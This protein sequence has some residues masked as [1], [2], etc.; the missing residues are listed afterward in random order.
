MEYSE[1]AVRFN[2]LKKL[3]K[4]AEYDYRLE[5]FTLLKYRGREKNVTLPNCFESIAE[6]AFINN[7]G[8]RK[9]VIP[10]SYTMIGDS[11]FRG[12]S[13][14]NSVDLGNI[15]I[16]G[17]SVFS[18]CGIWELRLPSSV[19][20]VGKLAFDDNKPLWFIEIQGKETWFEKDSFRACK[21]VS[22]LCI[23]KELMIGDI[24]LDMNDI[25]INYK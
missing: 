19:T 3:D 25:D 24:G 17:N 22:E 6:N 21:N 10:D 9:V 15:I 4:L 7:K 5:D 20:S 23:H 2:R 8:I 12:C 14:L 13:N 11:A 18:S 1:L 16:I